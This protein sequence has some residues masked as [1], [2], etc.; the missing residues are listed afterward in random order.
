ML[1]FC[2]CRWKT[3]SKHKLKHRSMA[4]VRALLVTD[5]EERFMGSM[6]SGIVKSRTFRVNNER[7]EKK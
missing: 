4:S 6:L 5:F 7:T 1:F 2:V 3:L